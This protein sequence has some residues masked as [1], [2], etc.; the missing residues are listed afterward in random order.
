MKR[1]PINFEVEILHDY[2]KE[3]YGQPCRLV[4][5]ENNYF[6]YAPD[7]SFLEPIWINKYELSGIA[8][9]NMGEIESA[10]IFAE[11]ANTGRDYCECVFK[12]VRKEYG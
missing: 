3:M 4:Y 5:S 7:D 9:K 11:I 10:N 8:L 1:L 2:V 12:T 6:A